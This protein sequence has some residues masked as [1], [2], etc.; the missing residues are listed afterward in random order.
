MPRKSDPYRAYRTYRTYCTYG[1]CHL[2]RIAARAAPSV[3]ASSLAG[4]AAIAW[5]PSA[6]ADCIDDAAMRHQVNPFVL[7]AIGWQ[8]SRLQ[9]AALGHNRDGSVDLGA[10]QINSVH[11]AD[12]A[13]YGIDARSLSDGCVSAYVAAWHYR[14]QVDVYGNTWTA[15]GAYHSRTPVHNLRYANQ[16]AAI[17]KRW[18]VL[19][20]DAAAPSPHAP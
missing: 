3:V 4:L 7:R 20:N 5:L 15:V 16:I 2:A 11:L 12:L 10:F 17:L 8:E 6:K 18:K 19:G 9:S 1:T 14:H 13:R